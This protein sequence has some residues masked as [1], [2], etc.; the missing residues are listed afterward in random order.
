MTG[1]RPRLTRRIAQR[2]FGV[3]IANTSCLWGRGI[4]M[5][6][7]CA[8]QLC[9]GAL[10]KCAGGAEAAAAAVGTHGRWCW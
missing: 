10:D 3:V 2:A 5:C 9:V 8:L 1:L 4:K 6:L 7:R